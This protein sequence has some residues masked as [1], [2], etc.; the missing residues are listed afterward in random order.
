MET[1]QKEI[2]ALTAIS[3]KISLV[4]TFTQ[5]DSAKIKIAA[6]KDNFLIVGSHIRK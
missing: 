2:N 5:E 4:S 3:L 1:A 6:S